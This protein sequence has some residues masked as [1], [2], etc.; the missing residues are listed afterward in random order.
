MYMVDFNGLI[1]ERV[2]LLKKMCRAANLEEY[3]MLRA[4]MDENNMLTRAALIRLQHM[5]DKE[6]E[7]YI[8]KKDMATIFPDT[9]VG[10]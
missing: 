1:K 9:G 5:S 6:A 7:V 2:I 3:K 4:D 8:D 10:W